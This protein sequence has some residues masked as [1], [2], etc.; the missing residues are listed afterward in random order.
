MGAY[1]LRLVTCSLGSV[2]KPKLLLAPVSQETV[3][4][5][6]DWARMRQVWP[7]RLSHLNPVGQQPTK[8]SPTFIWYCTL[9][10]DVWS[11]TAVHAD[12]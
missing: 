10:P 2:V 7:L 4:R 8:V 1:R 11:A 5:V 12:V 3:G 6:A 9:H